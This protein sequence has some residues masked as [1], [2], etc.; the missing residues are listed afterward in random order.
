MTYINSIVHLCYI[1]IIL[2]V[3][4]YDIMKIKIISIRIKRIMIV[5]MINDVYKLL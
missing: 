5:E 4:L 1:I 3:S 2:I